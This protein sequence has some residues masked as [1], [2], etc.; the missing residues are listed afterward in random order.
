MLSGRTA[1]LIAGGDDSVI[2][3]LALSLTLI[4]ARV[5]LGYTSNAQ[6]GDAAARVDGLIGTI[7]ELGGEALAMPIDTSQP[8][9]VASLV[10]AVLSTFG[11]IDLLVSRVGARWDPCAAARMPPD[12]L[13]AAVQAEIEGALQGIEACLPVM[14]QNGWGRIVAIGPFEPV[15]WTHGASAPAARRFLAQQFERHER[16]HNITF[17]LIHPGWGVV[18]AVRAEAA[19]AAARHD[20]AWQARRQATAQD[21]ADAALFLCGESARFI[22]GSRLFFALE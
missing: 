11:K 19:I 22:S 6:E 8:G 10:G 7:R 1:L 4:R 17:N 16:P 20:S 13:D 12:A 15:C 21:I 3:S 9:A 14:R 5:A 18:P 2:R